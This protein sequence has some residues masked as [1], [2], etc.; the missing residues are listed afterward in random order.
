M[1]PRT[2]SRAVLAA[3][4][5]PVRPR[6]LGGRTYRAELGVRGPVL[7]A[8]PVTALGIVRPAR[9]RRPC[10]RRSVL[11]GPGYTH[12]PLVL[13][14]EGTDR[15]QGP[16]ADSRADVPDRA[17]PALAR[18]AGRTDDPRPLHPVGA[19]GAGPRDSAGRAGRRR[20]RVDDE[21]GGGARRDQPGHRARPGPV[22]WPG[23]RSRTSSPEQCAV[24]RRNIYGRARP[25][26]LPGRPCSRPS[27]G[28]SG[29]SRGPTRRRNSARRARTCIPP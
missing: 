19:A 14:L 10:R 3:Y 9:H 26:P 28:T 5:P 17:R 4:P 11:V 25:V 16:D 7:P 8:P 27:R 20:G 23:C 29:G 13:L 1:A 15:D 24:P 21:R 22:R 18:R 2:P 6:T 12:H